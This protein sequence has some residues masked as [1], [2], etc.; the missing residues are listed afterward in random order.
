[1]IGLPR[2]W[3]V[4]VLSGFAGA[5]EDDGVLAPRPS[6]VD[7]LAAYRGMLHDGTFLAGLGMRLALMFCAL[8]PLW[9]LGR[10]R[11]FGSLPGA[12]RAELL[13]RLLHH[14]IYIVAELTLLMKLCACM[15]LFRSP[16]VRARSSY[17]FEAVPEEVLESGERR[18]QSLPVVTHEASS[19][20]LTKEEVA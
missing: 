8:S 19:E 1:M 2:R 10:P 11:R 16:T 9:L 4:D 15:A 3:V 18:K 17:D 14:R 7:Y 5:D 6:E 13:N 12:E 20:S